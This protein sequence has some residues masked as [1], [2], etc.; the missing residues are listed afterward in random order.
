MAK[1][2][3]GSTAPTLGQVAELA[4]VSMATASKA[5]NGRAEVAAR[6][7][8]RVFDAAA[9]VGFTPNAIAQS[10][11]AGRTGT[12]GLITGDLEG[13][14]SIPI[15]MGAEDAFGAGS[16]SIFLCD[17]RGDSIRERHHVRALL[18][19]RID[20]LIVVGYETNPRPPLA[21]T[22]P[23]PVVYAYA[24]SS[25]PGDI[26]VA[27]DNIEAGRMA[28]DHLISCGRTRIAYIAG[29]VSYSAARDRVTGATE[30][31]HAAGLSL[32]GGE[33]M[34]G[35]WSEHWGRGAARGILARYPE[36]DGI[37]CGSD[38]IARGVIDALRDEGKDVPAEIAVMGHDNWEP[39]ATQSRPPLSTIDMNLKELG[40]VAAQLL[41]RAIEGEDVSGLHEVPCRVVPRDSTA[42]TL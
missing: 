41:F 30:A 23:V 35:A 24:P 19:R 27:S 36:V 16:T 42:L 29:D 34:Y 3:T 18:S 7:R 20:G 40:R 25:E 26:S 1:T 22:L 28:A 11:M 15:L 21:D 39:I 14:F 37:L 5:L 10:L 2:K 38:Q 12:V 33:A 13:R 31:L 9:K 32:L 4:G 17:A 8:Q 6:T